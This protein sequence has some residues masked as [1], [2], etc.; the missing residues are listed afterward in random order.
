MLKFFASENKHSNNVLPRKGT[1]KQ[2]TRG[3]DLTRLSFR[4]A[5]LPKLT[6]AENPKFSPDNSRIMSHLTSPA[7][8]VFARS[9]TCHRTLSS[10]T[11]VSTSGSTWSWPVMHLRTGK[12]VTW[13]HD[14]L[15]GKVNLGSRLTRQK[16]ALQKT[17]PH[18]FVTKNLR[19]TR[20]ICRQEI[21]SLGTWSSAYILLNICALHPTNP[22]LWVSKVTIHECYLSDTRSLICTSVVR[23][24]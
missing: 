20:G 14:W 5:Q 18:R 7:S 24:W 23:F 8:D 17:E 11:C 1:T 3:Q 15:A 16:A 13:C 4:V 9:Y 2:S 22:E 10:S 21:T 6:P 19:M 12:S